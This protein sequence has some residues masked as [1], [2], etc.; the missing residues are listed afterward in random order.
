MWPKAWF[1]SYKSNK[2]PDVDGKGRI[3]FGREPQLRKAY[4]GLHFTPVLRG[5][6]ISSLAEKIMTTLWKPSILFSLGNSQAFYNG[7]KVL[8]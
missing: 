1:I 4:T 7:N 5:K 3:A 6:D 8:I 2:E